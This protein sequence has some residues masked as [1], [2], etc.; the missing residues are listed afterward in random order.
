MKGRES[1]KRRKEQSEISLSSQQQP[2]L[3]RM[4]EANIENAENLLMLQNM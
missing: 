2:Q 3:H 4:V 1:I